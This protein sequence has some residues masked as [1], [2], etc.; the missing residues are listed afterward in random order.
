MKRKQLKFFN[1]TIKGN[2]MVERK[3]GLGKV[4]GETLRHCVLSHIPLYR[5][6]SLDACITQ[7]RGKI[8]ISHNPALGLPLET[9][10]F[11]A[12]HYAAS[13]V[14]MRFARPKYIAVGI[15][16][17]PKSTE[18]ELRIITKN[19]AAE[20]KRY[21]V[22]VVAGHTGV[23]KGLNV[24]LVSVTCIGKVIKK[25]ETLSSGDLIVA[26]GNVGAEAVWLQSLVGATTIKSEKSW[27]KLTPLPP[28]LKLMNLKGVKLMHD[29]SEGGVAG[30]LYEIAEK[31]N[32]K[33]NVQSDLMPYHKEVKK[34][35]QNQLRLPS[36]GV[37]VAIIEKNVLEAVSRVSRKIGYPCSVVGKVEKGH[38]AYVDSV[39]IEKIERTRLDEIYGTFLKH[40]EILKKL[41]ETLV[42]LEQH[43]EIS[44]LIPEVGTNVVHS[45]PYTES[46]DDI[47][48]LSG[49]VVVSLGR[50][51]VCGE[52]IYGGSKHVAL[53]LLEAMKLNPKIRAAVNIVGRKEVVDVLESI[54]IKVCRVPRL[55]K[56]KTCPIAEFIRNSKNFSY[57]Y[58]HPGSYALE[59]S[60]VILSRGPKKLL[61]ILIKVARHVKDKKDV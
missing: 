41:T 40:D 51:K 31:V 10:G 42:S 33:L 55:K 56:E 34:L 29:A 61:D 16:L 38:G 24:P 26:I 32:L 53:V 12:F 59:P 49:R 22:K 13:N 37:L 23:Y 11:F 15:N 2:L 50:P 54:N 30:A 9:L 57:A 60:I 28:S 20:A 18:E 3:L 47:A 36:Y 44:R 45:K 39:K 5:E 8:A 19:L 43:P 52:V 46:L 27:K 7:L 6:P 17:P 14:A 25:Q 1:L 21:N 4:H 58:Y 48:G 35:R